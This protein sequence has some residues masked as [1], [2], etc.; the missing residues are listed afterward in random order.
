[1][2]H[3]EFG[4]GHRCEVSGWANCCGARRCPVMRQ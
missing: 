2:K 1:M 3:H 4:S